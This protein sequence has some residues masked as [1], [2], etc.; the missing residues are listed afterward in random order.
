MNVLLDTWAYSAM[1]RGEQE[2]LGLMRRSATVVALEHGLQLVMQ[3][4]RFREI[5]SLLKGFCAWPRKTTL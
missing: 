1:R 2:I 3:D 5:H 4:G